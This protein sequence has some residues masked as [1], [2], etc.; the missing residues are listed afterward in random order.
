LG[1]EQERT[2]RVTRIIST[3]RL[4][5]M[6]SPKRLPDLS[7]PSSVNVASEPGVRGGSS[8]FESTR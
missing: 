1:D 5:N 7:R 8:L 4:E 3:N 6:T 2:I